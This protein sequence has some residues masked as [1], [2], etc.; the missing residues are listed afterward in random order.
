MR[1]REWDITSAHGIATF[2]DGMKVRMAERKAQKNGVV[3]IVDKGR[4]AEWERQE[5]ATANTPENCNDTE[6]HLEKD[7][8]REGYEPFL[9]FEGPE[10]SETFMLKGHLEEQTFSNSFLGEVRGKQVFGKPP[11]KPGGIRSLDKTL[12]GEYVLRRPPK[13]PGGTLRLILL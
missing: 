12:S 13:K 10:S 9:T 2:L 6:Q 3:N 4:K 5:R 11:K 8:S 7:V 1:S